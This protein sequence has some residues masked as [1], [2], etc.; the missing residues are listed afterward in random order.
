L[1]KVARSC[2]ISDSL[3]F[4]LFSSGSFSLVEVSLGNCF[5]ALASL[6]LILDD[7]LLLELAHALDFVQVDHKALIVAMQRLDTLS[8]ENVQVIGA[9]EMFNTL[10]VLLAELF[11]QAVL[12]F[13]LKVKTG[14]RENRVFLYHLVKNVDVEGQTLRTLQL[15]DQLATDGAA[16]S[17]LVVQL[18]DAVSAQGVAAV[19]QDTGN[20]FA[21]V[22]L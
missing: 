8:T 16:N 1:K 15:L 18:L 14:A 19:D 10:G 11:L 2:S 7:I 9:V 21:D 4:H 5:V 12:V 3:Q 6:I 17:V 22:V 20:P 13:I